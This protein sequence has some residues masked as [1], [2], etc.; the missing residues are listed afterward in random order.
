MPM[1]TQRVAAMQVQIRV[2]AR[3]I[4]GTRTGVALCAILLAGCA[5]IE[6]WLPTDASTAAAVRTRPLHPWPPPAPESEAAL[7]VAH[8]SPRAE[9]A[10]HAP[11]RPEPATPPIEKAP[12]GVVPR[13][14]VRPVASARG[15]AKVAPPPLP[16]LAF[17]AAM[18]LA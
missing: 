8:E 17:A 2:V 13:D 18:R 10:Q 11:I 14:T 1:L 4:A 3:P 6:R 7:V 16:A 5:A 9:V 12:T 15:Q